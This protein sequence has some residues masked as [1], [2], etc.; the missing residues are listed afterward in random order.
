MPLTLF[1][2]T[3]FTNINNCFTDFIR[4]ILSIKINGL[5]ILLKV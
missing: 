4:I 5:V 1:F 3:I 2:L